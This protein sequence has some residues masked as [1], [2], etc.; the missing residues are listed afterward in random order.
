[1][2]ALYPYHNWTTFFLSYF[3]HF[4]IWLLQINVHKV[5]R[6]LVYPAPETNVEDHEGTYPYSLTAAVSDTVPMILG[7]GVETILLR[8][9]A[10][11]FGPA[12]LVLNSFELRNVGLIVKALA[13][14]WAVEWAW[15]EAQ[16]WL[17]EIWY[18]YKGHHN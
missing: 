1:M 14:E 16:Y 13:A 18:W 15:L 6:Q 8:N 3:Y 2:K 17:N 11:D 5:F 10:R 9:L 4:G 12:G 7:L